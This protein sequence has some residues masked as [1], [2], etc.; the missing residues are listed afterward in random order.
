MTVTDATRSIVLV[1]DDV[2]SATALRR[3][4][5]AD[6][7][8]VNHA[9][10]AV[11]AMDLIDQ[12]TPNLIITDMFLPATTAMSLLHELQSHPDLAA[13][14]VI[15]CSN[16]AD[17]LTLDQLRP[18]GVRALLDKATMTPAS[19]RAAVHRAASAA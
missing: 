14:P 3:V 8:Q 17:R 19:I 6:D 16:A 2:W 18:Y 15:L 12:V 5:E 11:A 4:L 10:H 1:E 9:T 7:W 13:I